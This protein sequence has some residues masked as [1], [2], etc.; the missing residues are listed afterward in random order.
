MAAL[1]VALAGV[2]GLQGW[3]TVNHCRAHL[4]STKAVGIHQSS[5]GLMVSNAIKL[6]RA[7][8]QVRSRPTESSPHATE[9]P[10]SLQADLFEGMPRLSDEQRSQ[11]KPSLEALARMESVALAE[12]DEELNENIAKEKQRL[13]RAVIGLQEQQGTGK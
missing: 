7:W 2:A 5:R 13:L 4:V 11:L 12:N 10:E 3:W 6:V 1:A 9:V 8:G